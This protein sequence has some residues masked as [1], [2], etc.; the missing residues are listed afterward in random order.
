MKADR[1][2]QVVGGQSRVDIHIGDLSS[3]VD[4]WWLICMIVDLAGRMVSRWQLGL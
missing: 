3:G 4:R 1:D 2:A